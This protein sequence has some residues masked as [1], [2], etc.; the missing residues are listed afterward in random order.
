MRW[1]APLALLAAAVLASGCPE[2]LE[3]DDATEDDEA[4]VDDLALLQSHLGPVELP[5]APPTVGGQGP[6]VPATPGLRVPA[7]GY[8]TRAR[9]DVADM[10][11]PYTW[12]S[13][14]RGEEHITL[15]LEAVRRGED[16]AGPQLPWLHAVIPIALPRG[17]DQSQLDR[18]DLG[19]EALAA[20]TASIQ[21]T[22]ND[23]WLLSLTHLRIDHI[24]DKRITGTLEGVARRGSQGQR[25]RRFAAGF[26][27]LRAQDEG[28]E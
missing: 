4:A 20:A 7:A 10:L 1:G 13:L 14:L 25:E 22:R 15:R 19:R 18:L 16:E 17:T 11:L 27:A 3:V 26:L 6:I 2:W 9:L 23:T 24:D 12:A 5:S 28:P 8:W 21:T